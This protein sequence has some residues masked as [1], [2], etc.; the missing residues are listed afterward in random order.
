M[1]GISRLKGQNDAIQYKA[2]KRARLSLHSPV[3]GFC[4][5]MIYP[6]LDQV[7]RDFKAAKAAARAAG[8]PPKLVNSIETKALRTARKTTGVHA[9]NRQSRWIVDTAN[10]QY[11]T[12][13]D[14]RIIFIILCAM[15]FEFENAP[16]LPAADQAL[17]ES[18]LGKNIVASTYQ[19][20]LLLEKL[21]YIKLRDAALAPQHGYGIYHIGHQDPTLTPR[22]KP[23]NIAWR[24]SRSNLIQGNMTL[25]Q[26]RIYLLK[27]IG[28]YFE[29]GELDIV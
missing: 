15:I 16:A 18:Y 26:S 25:R 28:R 27:L 7:R 29:L 11:A 2:D 22:H 3:K 20:A 24:T 9:T 14:S 13:Y 8:M 10:P 17:F 12:E 4:D 21:D 5:I 1:T 23:S 6:D 19:D